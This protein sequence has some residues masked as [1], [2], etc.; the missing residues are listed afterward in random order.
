MLA[1]HAFGLEYR[2]DF[3]AG[4]AGIKFIHN[5]VERGKIVVSVQ[6]VH[7]VIDGNQ[8]DAPLPQNFHGLAD[9]QIVTLHA[10]HVFYDDGFH[11]PSLNFFHHR[12]KT[13]AVEALSDRFTNHDK[14]RD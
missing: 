13:G 8:P 2:T 14:N 7:A 12:Q 1:A 11:A 5:V 6:A 9:F 3:P 4:I 10:A